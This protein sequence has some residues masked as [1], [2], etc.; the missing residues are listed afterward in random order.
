MKRGLYLQFPFGNG[1]ILYVFVVALVSFAFTNV[2]S[3]IMG[4]FL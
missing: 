2:S 3:F 4:I 1:G